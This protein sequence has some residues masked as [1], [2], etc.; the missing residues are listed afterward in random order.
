MAF[1]FETME[2][3]FLTSLDAL[4]T[5]VHPSFAVTKSAIV[6]EGFLEVELRIL[7]LVEAVTC[8]LCHP[9]LER[10]CLG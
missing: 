2:R 6:L 4:K 7:H 9:L 3:P 5:L 8:Y 10:L 1:S